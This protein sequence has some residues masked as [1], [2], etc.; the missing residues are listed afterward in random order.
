MD[1]PLDKTYY[2]TKRY[3]VICSFG[4][5]KVFFLSPVSTTVSPSLPLYT[6]STL[7]FGISQYLEIC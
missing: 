5:E 3:Y 6:Q 1:Y 4:L 2:V 7:I